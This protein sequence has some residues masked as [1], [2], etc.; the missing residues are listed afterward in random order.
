ETFTQFNRDINLRVASLAFDTDGELWATTWPD[1]SQVVR[2]T[3]TRRAELMLDFDAPVDSLAFG[4]AG[5]DLEGLLFVSQNEGGNDTPGSELTMVDTATLRR[6]SIADGGSRGDVL[7]TTRDGKVLISQ[8]NQ[9]DVLNPAIA[10]IVIATNPPADGVAATPLSNLTITFDQSM[11]VGSGA[12]F[13]S[14]INPDNYVLV[15]DVH[16]EIDIDSV[17]FNDEF[18]TAQLLVG[19][20]P[21]DQYTLTVDGDVASVQQIPMGADYS[22]SF[23]TVVD[24]TAF[25]DIEFTRV[26]SHRSDD[27][28]SWDVQITNTS[29]FDLVLPVIL[30]LDPADG[31]PGVPQDIVGQAPDGRWF[32]EI[33]TAILA[34][35]DSTPGQTVTIYNLNDRR[36]DL[37]IGVGASPGE[38]QP[39]EFDTSPINGAAVGA[40]YL[41]ES[42][43]TDPDG[44]SLYYFLASGPEGMTVDPLTGDVTWVPDEDTRLYEP[45]ELHVY[46]TRG[47]RDVQKFDIYVSEGNAAP[48]LQQFPG[49]VEGREGEPIELVL[50]VVDPDEDPIAIWVDRLPPGGIVD[51]VTRTFRWTPGFD[52]AG[53]YEGVQFH[54]SDGLNEVVGQTT[55]LIA[56]A[57][58][59]PELV[60]PAEQIVREGD[61]LRFAVQGSD[62]DGTPVTFSSHFLPPGAT[63]HPLTGVFDWTPDFFQ[64]TDQAYEVPIT[65]T[66]GEMSI[67]RSISI[68]V[69]NANGAPVFDDLNE[70]RIFESQPLSLSTF[71]FDPDNPGYE[72]PIRNEAGELQERTPEFAKS[73]DVTASGL[74]EGAIFDAEAMFLSW[75]P[76]FTQAGTYEITFT[77]VDDGDGTGLPLMTQKSVTIEVMNLNRA[78]DITPID[79]QTV[80]RD[81]RLEIPVS[82]SDADGNPIDWRVENAMPGFPLPDFVSFTDAGDGTGT[83]FVEPTIGDRGDYGLTVIAEDDGDGAGRWAIEDSNFTFIVDVESLNEPPE[84]QHIGDKVAVVGEPIELTVRVTDFDEEPLAYSLAGLPAGATLTPGA[85]Y[86]T[87]TL[88]WT[89]TLADVGTYDAVFT[90]TDGGNGGQTAAV[91]DAETISVAVREANDS[92]NLTAI[93]DQVVDEGQLLQVQAV[94]SDPDGD[95]L[96][97]GGRS[98]PTGATVDPVTGLFSWTPSSEQAG[99]FDAVQIVADDGHR[100]RVVGFSILVQNVNR[101]PQIVPRRPLFMREGGEL[102]FTMEAGDLDGDPIELTAAGLPGDATFVDGRFQWS[103][104]FEDAGEYVVTF[105]ATDR[106]GLTDSTDVTIRI[107]NINRAPIVDTSFRQVKLGEELRFHVQATDPDLGT[108][109]AYDALDLPR[110]ATIDSASGE[111][112][113][114]PGPDQAGEYLVRLLVSDGTDTTSQVIVIRASVELDAPKVSVILTP[115]F[116]SPGGSEILVHAIADSLADIASIDVTVD[117]LPVALDSDGMGT[118]ISGDPGRYS[119]VATAFDAD[120]LIGTATEILR[121]RDLTDTDPPTVDLAM[122]ELAILPGGEIRGT[123][124]DVN[125]DAWTLEIRRFGQPDYQVLATGNEPITN[126][127]LAT[128]DVADLPNDYYELRLSAR[129]IGRL[130][131]RAERVVE[132][133]SPTK[134]NATV[135]ATDLTANLGGFQLDVTRQYDSVR[136]DISGDLGRGWRW[137]GREID[138]RAGV[139]PTGFES[140]GLFSAFRDGTRVFFAGPSGEELG[141]TFRPVEQTVPGLSYHTPTWEAFDTNPDGWLLESID[142]VLSRGGSQYFDLATGYPFNPASSL[143]AG[144]D[145]VLTSPGGVRYS[146]DASVGITSITDAEGRTV[147][148]GDSGY[149]GVSGESVTW[150]TDVEGRVT[151]LVGPGGEVLLYSY[152]DTDNLTGVRAPAASTANRYGYSDSASPRLVASADI[153][154]NGTAFQY[155]T[156]QP[157]TMTPIVANLGAPGTFVGALASDSLSGGETKHVGFSIRNSEVVSRESGELL[158]RVQVTGRNGL[159]PAI[160]EIG[161][162]TPRTTAVTGSRAEATFAIT[163]GGFHTVAVSGMTDSSGN[164]DIAIDLVGDLNRDGLVDGIDSDRM[165]SL[166]GTAAGDV[167]YD[168]LADIDGS[169]LIDITDQGLLFLNSG[170]IANAAPLANPEFGTPLTH[171]DLAIEFS[172]GESVIDPDGDSLFYELVGATSG[173]AT[174]SRD[175]RSILFDPDPGFDGTAS[176]QIRA[177][178][179][180]NA[181][182]VI[183]LPITVS[184]APL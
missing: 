31:Y 39:P 52:T 20:L 135:V 49:L 141:F 54:F 87:A 71:A 15:G 128:L 86:G 162:L 181:S 121:V 36:V 2:F 46:D 50:P 10:P 138:F 120:G 59:P 64:A 24:Y 139:L 156:G 30:I 182:G 174:L 47:G 5:T 57:D 1:R 92:P 102:E 66:S 154:G 111:V 175:G 69:I 56:P 35:G 11:F 177:D 104:G 58:Q 26:R 150:V 80:Q 55:F 110:G 88:S 103:P 123:V 105:T 140:Q 165:A 32:I 130:I 95:A 149:T 143:S 160:R 76:D 133:Y 145:F 161:G 60:L 21:A 14:V 96:T 98:L 72:T 85:I 97:F 172:L 94:A 152:D 169:G 163:Q 126:G 122:P 173:T 25:V 45:V 132:V 129:D 38:N 65:V 8:S 53:T 168:P 91:S 77:A 178:D 171:T 82:V 67:T 78:P 112:V 147:F 179:G 68:T 153:S 44:I 114:T 23:T 183:T 79:N 166:V 99:L 164:F 4:Q 34:P 17:F 89:P 63:L 48:E 28:V 134:N 113:W 127:V 93:P 61:R 155:V 116:P 146:I 37:G 6:V 159:V 41:Y 184:G 12:E 101:P 117:G 167:G 148:V 9:V 90:V 74:P 106:L 51:P 29:E 118:I 119:V 3:E 151:R 83:I 144:D 136:R 125:L 27:F 18:N 142:T 7:I 180:F 16:G 176:V 170:F 75:R 40:N 115:S 13:D 73:V 81:T 107:D 70:W 19:Q 109:L 157:P 33:Q 22:W 124:D 131:G 100:Q 137:L 108:L 62:P 43:A 84:W 42:S 158:I